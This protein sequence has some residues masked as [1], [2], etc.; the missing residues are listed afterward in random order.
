MYLETWTKVSSKLYLVTV[1]Q[2][3]TFRLKVGHHRLIQLYQ[4]AF[5]LRKFGACECLKTERL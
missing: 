5:D 4:I 1:Y 2:T 3:Q